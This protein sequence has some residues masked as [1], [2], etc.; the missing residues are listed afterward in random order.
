MKV[1]A[2]IGMGRKRSK[3]SNVFKKKNGEQMKKLNIL[4]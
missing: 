3:I 1:D 4:L 2:S